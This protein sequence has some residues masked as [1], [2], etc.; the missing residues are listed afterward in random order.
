M[1]HFIGWKSK[2]FF[3]YKLLQ[4]IGAVLFNIKH[5][6]YKIRIQLTDTP[7]AVEQTNYVNKI[8][9]FYMVHA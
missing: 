7:L 6:E 3:K 1:D 5:F 2:G 4:S 8:V 9:N